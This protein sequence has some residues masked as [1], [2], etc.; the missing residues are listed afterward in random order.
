[1]GGRAG[2]RGGSIVGM[3]EPQG[4]PSRRDSRS[5][6]EW[7]ESATG[8]PISATRRRCRRRPRARPRHR[9]RPRQLH[10]PREG[11]PPRP[12]PARPRRRRS[13]RRRPARP[14]HHQP[15]V[16]VGAAAQQGRRPL[17]GPARRPRP[18]PEPRL[19][20]PRAPQGSRPLRRRRLPLHALTIWEGRALLRADPRGRDG[21]PRAAH[22]RQPEGGHRSPGQRAGHR[23]PERRRPAERHL[24]R[25]P[26]RRH[27]HQR[28][29]H[30]PAD[31]GQLR[32][33][34]AEQGPRRHRGGPGHAEVVRPH[35]PRPAR[36]RLR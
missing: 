32:G 19:P 36:P 13:Q 34:R 15:Q 6:I 29:P 5:I 12:P 22:L 25:A 31:R 21:G 14:L 24:R 23:G 10:R 30:R 7:H 11:R 18:E 1:M 9:R 33:A 4:K 28:P 3:N 27:R 2:R 26:R 35:A 16:R 17:R 20:R 8:P